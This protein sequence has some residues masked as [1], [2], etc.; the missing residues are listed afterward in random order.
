MTILEEVKSVLR[1][2]SNIFDDG[3][4]VPLIDACKTD[5]KISGITKIDETD[6][7]VR[8]AICLYCKGNFGYSEDGT[9]FSE[10]YKA[11]RDSMSLSGFYT[12]DS[13]E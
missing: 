3:E 7:L 2:S 12:G 1:I 4:I 11:L 13:D 10:A 8:R 9:R 5:L 6:A